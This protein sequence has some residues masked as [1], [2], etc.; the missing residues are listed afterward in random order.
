VRSKKQKET[1]NI[2][3]WKQCHSY[4]DKQVVAMVSRREGVGGRE[5]YVREIRGTNF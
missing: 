5:K 2:T 4:R 3:I 1:E